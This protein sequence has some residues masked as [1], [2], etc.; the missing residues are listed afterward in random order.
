MKKAQSA[1]EAKVLEAIPNIG[2]AIAEDLKRLGIRVPADLAGH[3]PYLLYQQLCVRTG[4]RHDPCVLDTFI[5]ATRFMTGE[6]SKPW[7]H[8]TAERKRQ[9]A[10]LD[11]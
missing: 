7:W 8:Y 4:T 2:P 10:G 11:E 1:A 6:A 3:D 9:L 5:A